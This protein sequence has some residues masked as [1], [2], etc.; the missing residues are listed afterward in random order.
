MSFKGFLVIS[1]FVAVVVSLHIGTTV[2]NGAKTIEDD[3]G[4]LVKSNNDQMT[5]LICTTAT[6]IAADSS[7][8][9]VESILGLRKEVQPTVTSYIIK[10]KE[11]IYLRNK[12]I[13]CENL[14]FSGALTLQ[15]RNIW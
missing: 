12:K 2:T 10:G 14:N 11:I 5:T 4:T 1:C 9:T 8:A 13:I 3:L 6:N 7:K 15:K